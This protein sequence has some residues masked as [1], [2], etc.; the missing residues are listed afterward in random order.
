MSQDPHPQHEAPA[1]ASWPVAD[2]AIQVSIII[3]TYNRATRLRACLESVC[4]GAHVDQE[5][6]VVDDGSTD[7]TAAVVAAFGP[8][9]RYVHQRN[10]GPSAARNTGVRA[11][12]GRYIAFFDSDDRLLPEPRRRVLAF[13][14]RRPDIGVVFTDALVEEAGAASTRAFR[15][16]QLETFWALPHE[17]TP[18][19]LRVFDPAAFMRAMILDRCYLVPSISVIRRAALE[20]SG[21]FDERLIGYEE[22]DLFVRLAAAVPFAYLD[23]PAAVI[24]K[25]ESNLSGDLEKMVVSGVR[26]LDKVLDGAIALPEDLRRATAA[27]MRSMSFDAAYHAFVRGD[28]AAARDRFAA[29]MARW[30]TSPRALLYWSLTW[31]PSRQVQ[32]L[33][34]WKARP[35]R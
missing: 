5:V 13:L 26:V 8:E 29:H 15:R 19:G 7:D 25:H 21:L 27:K 1:G 18:D 30:G 34:E 4:N 3:P 31:L 35:A 9:V 22:W 12:R 17:M 11:S 16:S 23:E 33:R 2:P 10:A 32:R 28:A 6:V 24:E 14:D 20:T